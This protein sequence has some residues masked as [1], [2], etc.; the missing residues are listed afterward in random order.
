LHLRAAEHARHTTTLAYKA[1][2]SRGVDLKSTV[3]LHGLTLLL[4][5]VL[6]DHFVTQHE[7]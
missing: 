4:I 5:D 1:R 7:P 2:G 6:V 3:V